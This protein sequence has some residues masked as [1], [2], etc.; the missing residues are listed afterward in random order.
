MMI[1]GSLQGFRLRTISSETKRRVSMTT[2][3]VG[4]VGRFHFDG[5]EDLSIRHEVMGDSGGGCGGPSYTVYLFDKHQR[6]YCKEK[7]SKLTDDI[8]LGCSL[9][10]LKGT[11]P[12]ILEQRATMSKRIYK[13]STTTCPSRKTE[14]RL[15]PLGIR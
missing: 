1:F 13:L 9:Q 12:R 6:K 11:A 7:L 10:I 14:D 5:E 15:P 4:F 3:I 2:N 8:Y